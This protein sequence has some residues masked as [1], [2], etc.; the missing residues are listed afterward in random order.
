MNFHELQKRE[1]AGEHIYVAVIGAG[2]FGTRFLASFNV[3]SNY[4][5]RAL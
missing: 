4:E 3:Q 5:T 2:T 1:E